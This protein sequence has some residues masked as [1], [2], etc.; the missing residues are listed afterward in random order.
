MERNKYAGQVG[1][2]QFGQ[3]MAKHGMKAHMTG[4]DIRRNKRGGVIGGDD[5]E[6][7][8]GR[9]KVM[10]GFVRKGKINFWIVS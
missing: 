2:N 1:V 3:Y 5:F 6:V 7:R 4:Y 9:K 10:E 8:K